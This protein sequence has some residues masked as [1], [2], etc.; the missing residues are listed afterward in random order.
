MENVPLSI[1]R[2]SWRQGCHFWGDVVFGTVEDPV[3]TRA[4]IP[5]SSIFLVKSVP[6]FRLGVER[7]EQENAA[8]FCLEGGLGWCVVAGR[9]AVS[10]KNPTPFSFI[11]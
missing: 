5:A 10:K 2:C 4:A 6:W 3:S 11:L 1:S 7:I 8:S 9:L